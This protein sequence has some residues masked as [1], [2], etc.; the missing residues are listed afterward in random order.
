MAVYDLE[1]Q[2]QLS[3]LKAWWEKNGTF[4]TGVTVVLALA[5][6]GWQGWNWHKREQAAEASSLFYALQV[7]A[8]Q[9]DPQKS[10]ELAGRLISDYGGTTYAQFAA[11]ISANVQFKHK[12][13]DNAKVQLEWAADKGRDPDL[14][15]LARL[16][17][18]TVL[19][20]Q[21]NFDQALARLE[22]IPTGH[23]AFRF[24]DLRGD[25]LVAQGK[26][27]EARSSYQNAINA[28]TGADTQAG[29]LREIVLMKMDALGS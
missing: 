29:M 7:T 18:A 17:L 2:E 5:V 23:H 15:N 25:I 14:K 28:L 9:Q 12:E 27:A 1:E 3:A 26:T 11:L 13:F 6:V 10:R 16:R 4:L 8:E 22:P 20:A 21:E 24:N 19:F